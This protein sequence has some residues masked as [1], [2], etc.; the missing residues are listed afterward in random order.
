MVLDCAL[1]E[2]LQFFL[3]LLIFLL[4]HFGDDVHGV[5]PGVVVDVGR[6][7]D[8]TLDLSLDHLRPQRSQALLFQP[9]VLIQC[10]LVIIARYA[11]LNR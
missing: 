3:S 8:R 9:C 11:L 10:H 5:L 6:F 2:F 4:Y 1:V 7:K